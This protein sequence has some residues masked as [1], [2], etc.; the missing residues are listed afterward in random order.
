MASYE[1]KQVRLAGLVRKAELSYSSAVRLAEARGVKAT[2]RHKCFVSYHGADIDAV[3]TFVDDYNEVFIPR[4]VGVSD[5]DHFKDPVDSKDE[6]YIKAQIGAKYL[7]DS[8]VTILFVGACTWA[9]KYVDWEIS[10]SLRNDSV[11]KRNG[12]LAITPADKSLNKLP[13]RF[14]DN[15]TSDKPQDSYARYQYYPTSAELL[16]G[17]IQDAFDARTSRANLIKN[18]RELRRRN[19]TC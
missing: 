1:E 12:L 18:G 4:V 11:N 2:V 17:W 19:S 16:R 5:S 13:Y 9:R 14:E 8:S 15:H 6:E 3:T 7:S 10:S